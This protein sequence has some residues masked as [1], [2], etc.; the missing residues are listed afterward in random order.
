MTGYLKQSPL[1]LQFVTFIGFFFGFTSLYLVGVGT[2]FPMLTG[3]SLAA[4]QNVDLKDANLIGY[5]KIT[6]FLYTIISYFIPA[7][8]FAYLWQPSPM[9]YLGLKP[10]PK[11]WQVLLALMVMYSVLWFAGLVNQWNQTWNVPQAARDMQA[12]TEQ[13]VKIMLHMPQPKD[14]L[15]N[16]L[17][18]AAVPAIAEELF[19]RG[20]LQR[21][22]IKSTGKV[23]LSVFITAILFSAVHL[24]MLGFMARVVLGFVLGAIYVISGN[25]WLSIFAH[26]LNNGLQVIMIY[27][28]QHGMMKTDPT[29]DTPV[30]WYIGLLSFVV[31]I[32][33][34]WALSKKSTPMDMTDKPEK[35]ENKDVDHIGVDEN[36]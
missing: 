23:W 22:M 34:M 13:L 27:M 17:L 15:I 2:L 29:K 33:L 30:A 3:H 1:P 26:I 24:E 35:V 21:L 16:L 19:F 28:F 36:L 12:Q 4:L 32:G 6:Q 5:L 31:T 25:L 8:V 7:A 11:G 18:I 9:R 14:L 10:A 20:V